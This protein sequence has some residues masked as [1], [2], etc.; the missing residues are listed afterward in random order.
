MHWEQ[1]HFNVTVMGFLNSPSYVQHQMNRI[2]WAFW[3]FVWAYVDDIVI[4]FKT[5]EKHLQYLQ[6]VFSLFQ[7]L[8][9]TLKLCKFYLEYS[10]ITLLKQ[11]VNALSLTTEKKKMK[12]ITNIKFLSNLK[13]LKVYL[14]LMSWLQLYIPYYAQITAPLQLCKTELLWQS[15]KLFKFAQKMFICHTSIKKSSSEEMKAFIMLQ[16]LFAKPTFLAYFDLTKHLYIDVDVSKQYEFE[17]IVYHIDRDS[18]T[19][20]QWEKIHPI[21]FL[22][23]LLTPAE[24]KYWPTELE[25]VTLM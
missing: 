21:L 11:H 22:S 7:S 18:T 17:V 24:Q 10:N 25:T 1:K 5:L 15:L 13:E 8:G 23:K 12:A 19:N 16:Q 20:I 9:I 4:F 3:A 6:Q 2:L 14:E